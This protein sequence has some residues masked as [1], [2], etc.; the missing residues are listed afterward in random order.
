MLHSREFFQTVILIV[1]P[2]FHPFRAY[3]FPAI[4]AAILLAGC[5][6]K[7]PLYLPAKP[8]PVTTAPA[9]PPA[10]SKPDNK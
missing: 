6:Q 3:A 7:G 10:D 2:V 1:K 4:A 8:A 5:G 9:I